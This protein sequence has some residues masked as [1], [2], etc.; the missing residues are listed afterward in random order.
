MKNFI[1]ILSFLVLSLGIISPSYAISMETSK[2][3][4]TVN[5]ASTVEAKNNA[6]VS[7]KK[8]GAEISKGLYVLLAIVGLGFLA[9]GLNTDWN[10]NKWIIA[11]ILGLL[12]WLPGVIYSLVHMKDFY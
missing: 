6:T 9:I 5:A 1:A 10:G 8:D 2:S 4:V 11:L 7:V 3:I 12:F